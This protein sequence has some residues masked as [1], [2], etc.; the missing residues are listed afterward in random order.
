MPPETGKPTSA[1]KA[2]PGNKSSANVKALGLEDPS[3]KQS[4]S[5]RAVKECEELEEELA[6]LKAAYEQYFLGNDRLPPARPHEDFKKRLNKLKT[7]MV[8]NTAAKFRISSLQ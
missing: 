4:S 5:E 8:R 2:S 7:S 3:Q 1:A 6:T